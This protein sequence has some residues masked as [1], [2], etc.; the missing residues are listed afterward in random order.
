MTHHRVAGVSIPRLDAADKVT[1]RAQYAIDLTLPGTLHGVCVRSPL[2][3]G[4]I[5]SIDKSAAAEAKGVVCIITGEDLA[6]MPLFPRFGMVPDRPILAIE[7]VRFTGEPVAL[8]VAETRAAARDAA[9]KVAVDYED[10][11]PVMTL[12][13]ALASGA[14]LVHEEDL[15]SEGPS[16]M[17]PDGKSNVLYRTEHVWGDAER[18]LKTA[19]VV[20]EDTFEYPMLY[21]YAMEPYNAM[22]RFDGQGLTVWTSTH[23]PYMNRR[24][25]ARIFSLPLSKVRVVVPYVGG[26]YGTKGLAKVDP[27]AALGSW[28]TGRPV[29]VVLSIDESMQT[30]RGDSAR[31]FA[32]TGFRADGTMTARIFEILVPAGAYADVSPLVMAKMGVRCLGPYRVPNVRVRTQAVYTNTVP[33]AALRGFGGPQAVFAG[34]SLMNWGAE[35]L[36]IPPAD[37]RRVNMANR[38]EVFHQGLRGLDSDLQADLTILQ[39]ELEE[40]WRVDEAEQDRRR[41]RGRGFAV[42]ATNVGDETPV[43]T[44]LV[45]I[46]ADGTCS[47]LTGAV[48]VGQ[49]SRTVLA[50]I[51]AEEFGIPYDQVSII[52]SDTGVGTYERY[53]AAS[54]TTTLQGLAIQRAVQ[55]ARLRIRDLAADAWGLDADDVKKADGGVIVKDQFHDFGEVIKEWFGTEAGEVVGFGAVR[56]PG[57]LQEAPVFWEVGNVGVIVSIDSDTLQVRVDSIVTVGDCGFA[58]N[59]RL[60]EGQELG[61]A[62]GGIGGALFEELLYEGGE[63]INGTLIDYRVPR[64]TDFPTAAR[65]LL[66]NRQDGVGPYGARG[67]GEGAI[68]PV[69]AAVSAAIAHAAGVRITKLPV[70]PERLWRALRQA[71]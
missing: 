62:L 34:E 14:V 59:P 24:E 64:I 4:R 51:L 33:G 39:E 21:G 17:G 9:A 10:L 49:G 45:R 16:G 23:T 13:D 42:S 11:P 43:S 44:A 68:Q 26:N 63:M 53:T 61:A 8:V 70:T 19:T 12:E 7:R 69:G 65:C 40:Q 56:G 60:V 25:L 31:I 37:I 55:N 28:V 38:G 5:R 18:A 46:H 15:T 47:L 41:K 57:D 1:G 6:A 29:K 27:L 54:S 20:V 48:E 58:I 32:R 35:E 52:Q 30:A 2:P 36:G 50:Q 71:K 67:S 66:P 3:H 22:A